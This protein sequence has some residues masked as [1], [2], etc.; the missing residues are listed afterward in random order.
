M[1]AVEKR[2]RPREFNSNV[3]CS[4]HQAVISVES[5]RYAVS[6]MMRDHMVRSWTRLPDSSPRSKTM[7]HCSDLMSSSAAAIRS[8]A[9]G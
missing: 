5:L 8:Q 3:R 1:A 2:V 4:S 7:S 6:F 9:A